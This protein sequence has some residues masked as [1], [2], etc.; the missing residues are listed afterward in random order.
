MRLNDWLRILKRRR[1]RNQRSGRNRLPQ[2][3]ELL[4]TRTLLTFMF[5]ANTNEDVS[6]SVEDVDSVI[7]EADAQNM[8]MS[9]IRDADDPTEF[10]QFGNPTDSF[11]VS[12][13]FTT[14]DGI[15]VELAVNDF[16]AGFM[17]T[18]GASITGSSDADSFN[19]PIISGLTIDVDGANPTMS[20]GD[21]LSVDAG[22]EDV[23]V[24]ASG[25]TGTGT[26]TFSNIEDV[27]VSE[28]DS[29]SPI[30]V[31][32]DDT[33]AD[34]FSL[35]LNNGSAEV[36]INGNAVVSVPADGPTLMIDGSTDDDTLTIDFANGNPIPVG[37]LVYDGAAGNDDLEFVNVGTTFTTAQYDYTNATDG[38]ITLNDGASDFRVEFAGLEPIT[39][40]G[41]VADAVFNLPDVANDALLEDDGTANN[42]LIQL[43]S[44]NGT[45][46]TTIFANPTNSLTINGGSNTDSI[47]VNALDDGFGPLTGALMIDGADGADSITINTTLN[48]N[49]LNFTAE[50]ITVTSGALTA[51]NAISLD[52]NVVLDAAADSTTLTAVDVSLT[53]TV[54]STT[55]NEDALVITASGT[56]TLGGAAGDNNQE[57]SAF[58]S[59][60]GGTTEINGGAISVAGDISISD[61]VILGAN[62]TV[63]G[64][65]ISFTGTLDDDATAGDA[66]LTVNGTGAT[67]FGGAV[68]GNQPLTNVLT[69]A[70]GS[71]AVNASISTTGTQTFNDPVTLGTSATLSGSDISFA[72]TLDDDATAG[73]AVLIINASGAT[74]FDGAVGGN[75]PV[76]TLFTDAAGSTAINAS[77]STTRAQLFNDA[78]TL[79]TSVT[80]T[81]SD[82]NFASTLDDDATAGDAS[83]TINASAVTTFG[84]AVGGNQSLTSLSTDA[85]G[86]TAINASISTTGAQSFN[87]SLTLGT[88]VTLT[89]TDISFANTLDDD[90]TAGDADLIINASGGTTFAGDVGGNQPLTSLSTD[91]AGATAIN[92]SISTTA[93]QS[94]NDAVT[95]GTSVSLTGTD[96]SFANTLDD[97]GTAGDAN[98]TINASGTASFNNAVGGTQPLTSLTTDVDGT[99]AINAAVTTTANQIFN[100]PVTLG[101]DVTLTG[102]DIGFNNTLDD[103]ATAGNANLQVNASGTT[104][105]NDAV[106]SS[107]PLTS[108]TT[109]NAGTTSIGAGTV[110]TTGDQSFN[111]AVTL[112]ADT[113]ITGDNIL[114]NNTLDGNQNLSL[115]A[116][117]QTTFEAAVGGATPLGTGN[118]S[119]L[120]VQS[121]N[122]T[123]GATSAID[124][125][126]QGSL[127]V[128]AANATV[129]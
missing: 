52:G 97:D 106:G 40:D 96:I 56:A 58:T 23:M 9:I 81:G 44:A 89:G 65:N 60:G 7:I 84:G 124:V 110:T 48:A 49:D 43:R 39:N 101:V 92:A 114:F 80:L 71:T 120:V 94:F 103:D 2:V 83:L 27:I 53:G 87:D 113:T 128:L 70:A 29:V 73:D 116:A 64:T 36:S 12:F 54:R 46:E 38:T 78:V 69:D 129:G 67:T 117:T 10:L 72:N 123:L 126:L 104:T 32:A 3:A 57:L 25:I 4:E 20:P 11:S 13:S 100:D 61:A 98:L 33:T 125:R 122:A 1:S 30:N 17:P 85:A 127:E 14:S 18:M 26:I 19:L 37:G 82:I 112:A 8:G 75:Q 95:L 55:Q 50:T 118:G 119:A 42:G 105:F 59:D 6:I 76:T 62:T 107:Q 115:N 45:F 79:G 68:G 99:T 16:D 109:D 121:G 5:V 66:D 15:G 34:V 102:S 91:A 22:V 86:S 77:I 90:A 74:T 93:A 88:S 108:L 28:A 21:V 35:S 51:A 47:T 111:D 24:D 31:D 63:S 41:T